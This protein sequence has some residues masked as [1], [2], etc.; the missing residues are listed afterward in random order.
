MF[1]E[2]SKE[3]KRQTPKPDLVLENKLMV[4][5]GEVGREEGNRGWGFGGGTCPKEHWVMRGV[6]EHPKPV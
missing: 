4:T 6:V 3:K 5:R 1:C 2:V